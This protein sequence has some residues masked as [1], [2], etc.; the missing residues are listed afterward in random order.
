MGVRHGEGRVTWSNP[1]YSSSFSQQFKCR[2][3]AFTTLLRCY[4][5]TRTIPIQID[6]FVCI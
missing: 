5:T 2:L 4:H 1:E 3:V 6:F